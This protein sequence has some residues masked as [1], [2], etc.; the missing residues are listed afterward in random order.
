MN[1]E[2]AIP[3]TVLE[4][5]ASAFAYNRNLSEI[6]LPQNIE[7]IGAA[8]LWDDNYCRKDGLKITLVTGE[9]VMYKN[10]EAIVLDA[11][12]VIV[13]S[14][15]LVPLRAASEAFGCVVRK[16]MRIY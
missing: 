6:I 15:T 1:I 11:S 16:G 7:K 12:A 2:I 14:R 3:E 8:V 10:G 5:G 4:T 9:N 13:N